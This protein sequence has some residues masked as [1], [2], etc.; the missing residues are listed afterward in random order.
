[1][2]CKIRP[3]ALHIG[4][5]LSMAASTAT[6]AVVTPSNDVSPLNADA[7]QQDADGRLRYIVLLEQPP[8]A[9]YDGSDSH[10]AAIPRVMH[11]ESAGTGESAGTATRQRIDF[12][13]AQAE[14]YVGYLAAEQT[15]LLNAMGQRIARRLTPVFALQHALNALVL[16]LTPEEAEAIRSL[17]KVASVAPDQTRQLTTE[18]STALIGAQGIG[19]TVPADAV[20]IDGFD[21]SSTPRSVLGEGTV[22]GVL[23]TGINPA[24][25]SFAAVDESGYRHVNPLGAGTYRGLCAPGQSLAG[26]C[27]DKLIGIYDTSR[28]P[29]GLDDHG[30]GSH[31]ASTAAGNN[32]KAKY[33]GWD[34]HVTGV[35][36]HAN[37]IA[38][39]VCVGGGCDESAIVAATDQAVRDGVVDSINFSISG[40][41][42]PWSDATSQGFLSATNAGIFVAAAAGNTNAYAKEALEGTANHLE[43]W[44]TTVAA[45][46]SD[47]GVAG[48]SLQ[49]TGGA[50]PLPGFAVHIASGV[51]DPVPASVPQLPLAISPSYGTVGDGCTA[52]A[53]QLFQGK[54]A[55][56]KTSSG[57]GSCYASTMIDN[58][59][60]AGAGVVLIESANATSFGSIS[61]TGNVLAFDLKG[62]DGAALKQYG[63]ANPGALVQ[64][65]AASGR[66]TTEPDH[67]AWFSLRGPAPYGFGKPDL[68]MPGVDIL[69]AY[70]DGSGTNPDAITFMSGTSMATPHAAGA[71][72]LLRAKHPDWTPLE[73]KSALM[74]TAKEGVLE[75]TSS[76]PANTN[77][78]GSGR[79][80]VPAAASA[81]LV[82][83]ETG[84]HF[85][86]ANPYP[87]QSSVAAGD[88]STLNLA[89]IAIP[90]CVTV[91]R[92]ARTST[93]SCSVSRDFR[94][95]QSHPVTWTPSVAGSVNGGVQFNPAQLTV[96]GG[97]SQ[98]L[99][100]TFDSTAWTGPQNATLVL[101]PDDASLS[102]LHLPITVDLPVQDIS[103]TPRQLTVAAVNN[104]VTRASL[105]IANSGGADLVVNNTSLADG[106]TYAASLI[107]QKPYL[108]FGLQAMYRA[109]Y[110]YF[111]TP[112]PLQSFV[113]DAPEPLAKIE[114]YLVRAKGLYSALLGTPQKVN[115]WI[116]PDVSGQPANPLQTPANA[117]W[118]NEITEGSSGLS[119]AGNNVFAT[120]T[121]DFTAS[122]AIAGPTLAPGKYWLGMGR[123]GGG[124]YS[125]FG[126]SD[127]TLWRPTPTG[128]GTTPYT[129]TNR[130]VSAESGTAGVALRIDQKVTCNATPAW[131][132]VDPAFA[133]VTVSG[134][135]VG[136]YAKSVDV[137]V[138][139]SQFP[140]GATSA[141]GSLCLRSNDPNNPVY[142][143][144]V[145]A[146]RS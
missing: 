84:A 102:K 71:G 140:A 17:P 89:Q 23:D 118:A 111:S 53:A 92:V 59:H 88:P 38:Y 120:D 28:T 42:T 90:N 57:T 83:N 116:V 97:A 33:F 75:S 108:G 93:K 143:V 81:G 12:S 2:T 80:Q 112:I 1:M 141:T 105:K 142:R 113:V 20:F 79:V 114:T 37:I 77:A 16:D 10:F 129:M 125:M 74:M 109:P 145:H 134:G 87:L 34:T 31:T 100:V 56:L 128:N 82:L 122:G 30:H 86:A 50:T 51:A 133:S 7:S 13:G 25:A 85:T 137:L 5:A 136:S 45:T 19:P 132:S 49:A 3:L 99:T 9:L 32:R 52:F 98:R 69:A 4:L 126:L 146:T 40:G 72:L 8:A 43:P 117:L 144:V 94:S 101:T 55:L 131:L 41:F 11:R 47:H 14:A 76:T 63:D 110:G 127:N 96:A 27:N 54:A 139:P 29:V 66:S 65:S 48:I 64:V 35:A 124:L 62:N 44:V 58:A 22:L 95:T 115:Y 6:H 119:I 18:Y 68:A 73:I 138:D 21:G 121:L 46:T 26:R 15:T 36:P 135:L 39:K 106:S 70:R 107:D 67:M 104:Q 78:R 103:A 123:E 130:A 91:D 61:A 24:N 60:N